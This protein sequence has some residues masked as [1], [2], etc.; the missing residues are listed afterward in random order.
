MSETSDV[1]EVPLRGGRVNEGV[2]RV[3]DTVR[4]PLRPRSDFAR[5]LLGH[6][7]SVGFQ[8][9][10]RFLGIDERGREVLSLLAGEPLPGDVILTDKQLRSAAELL[11]NYHVAAASADELRGSRETI[12]HGDVGP[13]NILWQGE[14]A[15]A[16]IDFDEARPGERLDDIGY[17]AWKGLLLHAAG[18]PASEQRRRLTVLAEAYEV[19]LDSTLFAAIDRAYQ[20]MIDKGQ[21]EQWPTHTI[22]EIA[23][24]RAWCAGYADDW[25]C[26]ECEENGE[27]D[28]T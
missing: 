18:P 2:V 15:L 24:Q 11:R 26:V 7:A 23:A 27:P 1:D 16:L 3:G 28:T 20:S 21:R 13:W 25:V 22:H 10:P 8:G 4:R 5:R 17:F 12:V 6:L 9:A 19:P 14:T